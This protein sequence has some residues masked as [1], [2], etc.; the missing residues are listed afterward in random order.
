MRLTTT[1]QIRLMRASELRIAGSGSLD[2]IAGMGVY[3]LNDL[4]T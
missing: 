3:I 4:G 2:K 1:R